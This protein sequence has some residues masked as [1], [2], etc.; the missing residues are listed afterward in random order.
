M[1]GSDQG[2]VDRCEILCRPVET[3]QKVVKDENMEQSVKW[4]KKVDKEKADEQ[5][6]T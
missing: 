2:R 6:R 4:E 3:A 1:A 5:N